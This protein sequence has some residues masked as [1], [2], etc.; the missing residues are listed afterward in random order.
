MRIIGRARSERQRAPRSRPGGRIGETGCVP[1]ADRRC[2][3]LCRPVRRLVVAGCALLVAGGTLLVAGCSGGAT[4]W[5]VS[6]PPPSAAARVAGL[7]AVDSAT[8]G[9]VVIDGQGYLVYRSDRDSPSRSAC[10]DACTNQWLPVPYTAG[11]RVAGIDRQLVGDLVRPDGTRQ[12][13]LAGWPLY[14]YA[15]DLKPG[16]ANGEDLDHA[17]YV[18]APDGSKASRAN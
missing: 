14:G 18:I 10:L 7:F 13:T 9:P 12:A 17:W 8:L 6:T 2:R 11:L 5:Q 3:P 1:L 4:G 15:G 16:D